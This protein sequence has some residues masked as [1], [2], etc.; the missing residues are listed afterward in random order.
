MRLQRTLLLS[1]LLV[2]STGLTLSPASAAPSGPAVRLRDFKEI[3]NFLSQATR[4]NEFHADVRK[5]YLPLQG[6]L[7]KTG[8]VAELKTTTILSV[9]TLS[10]AYCRVMVDRDAAL[11][12]ASASKRY[13]HHG[14]D[15]TLSPASLSQSQRDQVLADYAAIFWLRELSQDERVEL[16][17]ALDGIAKSPSIRMS[18]AL[19]S[20]CA[21]T[22]SNL[23]A[24]AN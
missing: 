5:A 18:D 16:L 8:D 4:V 13:L 21:V 22:A 6:R 10:T 19:T 17:A 2:S 12:G 7:P 3:P 15:F 1:A 9:L 20:I 14:I 24:L 11:T 23:T